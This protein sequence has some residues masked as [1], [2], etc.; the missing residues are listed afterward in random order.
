M[1]IEK[2]P[3]GTTIS[4]MPIRASSSRSCSEASALQR[5]E[6]PNAATFGVSFTNVPPSNMPVPTIVWRI[7]IPSAATALVMLASSPRRI[8]GAMRPMTTPPGTDTSGSRV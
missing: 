7:G 8:S 6:V 4:S 5:I 2:P 1:W 3:I